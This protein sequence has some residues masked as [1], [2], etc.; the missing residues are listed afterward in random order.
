MHIIVLTN[1][2]FA[3]ILAGIEITIHYGFHGPTLALDDKPQILLRQ[4]MVR[5]LRWLVPAF[6][7][8]SAITT[9]VLVMQSNS[10]TVLIFRLIASVA[11]VVWI[12][13]RVVGTVKINSASLEWDAGNPPVDW[14]LQIAK[15][16][17]YHALGTWVTTIAY[18]FLLAA[19]GLV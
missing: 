17:K 10:T 3:G 19:A 7:V 9:I 16:E 11:L 6:F 14:K 13:T 15:A 2:F 8:P 18:V 12:C 1:F 5:R 4:G